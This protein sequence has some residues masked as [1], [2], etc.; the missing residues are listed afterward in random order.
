MMKTGQKHVRWKIAKLILMGIRTLL[1]LRGYVANLTV[2][3]RPG[4]Q[5]VPACRLGD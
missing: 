3:D 1:S 2:L 5:A 4:F